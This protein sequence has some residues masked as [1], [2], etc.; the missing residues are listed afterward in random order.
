MVRLFQS[1]SEAVVEVTEIRDCFTD[2]DF[3]HRNQKEVEDSERDF[4]K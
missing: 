1:T 3:E 2:R 4:K